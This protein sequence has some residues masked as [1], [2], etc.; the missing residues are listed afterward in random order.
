[1][2]KI[3][4]ILLGS[5]IAVIGFLGSVSYAQDKHAGYYYPTPQTT[6][7]YKGRTP[8]F[9]EATELSRLAFVTALTKQSTS[10]PY[11]PEFVIFSKGD[12]N[13][14]AIITAVGSERFN[15]LYR[16]RALL[17]MLTS[18]SRTTPIFKQ[19]QDSKDLTFLDMLYMMGFTQITISDGDQTAHQII[20]E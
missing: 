2:A 7:V 6:E 5:M 1:M 20:F 18:L 4:N 19:L 11:P 13:Q 15:T 14:K 10:S 3:L 9:P 12:Q 16:L 8:V 17:A